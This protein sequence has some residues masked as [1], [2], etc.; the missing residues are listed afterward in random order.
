[1]P[2]NSDG[3]GDTLAFRCPDGTQSTAVLPGVAAGRT[4]QVVVPSAHPNWGPGPHT[5]RRWVDPA[6][7]HAP[8]RGTWAYERPPPRLWSDSSCAQRE[9]Q[10]KGSRA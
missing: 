1:M 4:L 6:G 8:N 10:L 5:L 9:G 7:E 2:N 3:V